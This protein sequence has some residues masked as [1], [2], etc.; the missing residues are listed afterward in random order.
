VRHDVLDGQTGYRAHPPDGSSLDGGRDRL[1]LGSS[2][3]G[4]D[5]TDGVRS[6]AEDQAD[7]VCLAD[8]D[9]NASR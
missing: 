1:L 7:E 3:A 9:A 4:G 6:P 2:G 5:G 8:Y